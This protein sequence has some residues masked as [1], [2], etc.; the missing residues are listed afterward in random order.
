MCNLPLR[1]SNLISA[2]LTM[3]W[4]H[5]FDSTLWL[6][7]KNLFRGDQ[8]KQPI[9]RKK[10]IR[11]NK[12]RET[13]W[14]ADH[15]NVNLSYKFWGKAEAK[16]QLK[17]SLVIQHRC[18]QTLFFPTWQNLFFFVYLNKECQFRNVVLILTAVWFVGF[19]IAIR[20]LITSK[21]AGDTVGCIEFVRITR[22][23]TSITLRGS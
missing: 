16:T 13:I 20:L 18:C 7:N 12:I 8:K 6:S 3:G 15:F 1:G 9:W 5:I 11:E 23:L 2:V 19:I 4:N 21:M 22:E 17:L 14:W 10:W